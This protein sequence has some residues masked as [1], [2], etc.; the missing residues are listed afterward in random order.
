[1]AVSKCDAVEIVEPGVSVKGGNR[2]TTPAG[3]AGRVCKK[4]PSGFCCVQ[5]Q[6][7]GCFRIH[8]HRLQTT[9]QVAPECSRDCEQGC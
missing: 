9:S 1:M 6:G 2:R 4:Y 5:L 7:L 3:L 8:Q